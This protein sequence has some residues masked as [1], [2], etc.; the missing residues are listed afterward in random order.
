MNLYDL[1]YSLGLAVSSPYWLARPKLRA[2]VCQAFTQRMGHDLQTSLAA[3]SHEKDSPSTPLDPTRITRDGAPGILIH[4][5]SLGEVNATRS[6]VAA[7]RGRLERVRFLITTTTT[8]GW[9]RANQ[10]YADVPDVQLARFPL[11]FSSAIDRI[12]SGFCPD[13]VVLMELEVWPNFIEHCGRRRIPVLLVNGR[14][15]EPSFN[16][17]RLL[18]PLS[19]RM[20]RQLSLAAVQE[21]SYADQFIRL[22]VPSGHVQVAGTMK[23]DTAEVAAHVVGDEALA[24]DLALTAHDPLWVCGSTGPGEE[25]RVLN[26][27]KKLLSLHPHLRLA[28]IPRHP[29]RFESVANLIKEYGFALIQRSDTKH[30][31]S[32]PVSTVHTLPSDAQGNPPVIL[33]DTM[34]ELRKFYSLATAVFVGRTLVD[35]G[36]RQ[37]GSD[38]IEP[39][40]LAKPVAV[41][42]FISNFAEVVRALAA[43]NAIVRIDSDESLFDTLQSWLNDPSSAVAMGRRAQQVVRQQRGASERNAAWIVRCLSRQKRGSHAAADGS[44]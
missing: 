41:G 35:L 18:G 29:E 7:L 32:V 42:P 26:V 8:T 31:D 20:F 24:A 43:Q 17:Y 36:P 30:S 3:V 21:Q 15:T 14:L 44:V 4:A 13:V 22:G 27:Y 33:G 23:F 1:L 10:L 19:R 16:R 9:N 37:H 2:K 39:A 25:Q 5:V 40:A 11:D 28:I 34:G 38:M 12:L 6:L